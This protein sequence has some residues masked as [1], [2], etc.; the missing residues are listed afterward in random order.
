MKTLNCTAKPSRQTDFQ[1]KATK[2][3]KKKS[4]VSGAFFRDA[5]SSSLRFLLFKIPFPALSAIVLAT[6]DLSSVGPAREDLSSIALAEEECQHA[7][8]RAGVL[9]EAER[10]R[11]RLA[12][13]DK[14]AG[15]AAPKDA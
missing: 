8:R 11:L 7:T 9:T 13:A 15:Q 14:S 4:R 6:A 1:Q 3:T 5:F 10:F 2:I 12:T